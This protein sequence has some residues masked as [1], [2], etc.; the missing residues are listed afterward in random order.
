M[1]KDGLLGVS[2][3]EVAEEKETTTSPS[4]A[5]ETRSLYEE[6][7]LWEKGPTTVHA[8]NHLEESSLPKKS[9]SLGLMSNTQ[10]WLPPAPPG[11]MV[12]LIGKSGPSPLEDAGSPLGILQGAW[13]DLSSLGSMQ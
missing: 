13:L 10:S 2:M 12:L 11:F 4:P 9:D 8:P 5:E 6:P 3:L 7:E 1:E